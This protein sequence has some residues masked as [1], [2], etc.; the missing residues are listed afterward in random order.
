MYFQKLTITDWKQFDT[1]DIDF[2][3]RLTVFTGA[4]G[5][6]KTTLLHILA[7]HFGWEFSELA[8]PALDEK[9]GGF[10]YWISRLFS[11]ITEQDDKTIT[12][13]EVRYSS[14]TVA[15][16]RLPN[17][18]QAAYHI[19]IQNRQQLYGLNILSHRIPF[20]YQ[21]V[22]SIKTSKISRSQASDQFTDRV[23]Q[24]M[25]TV[26]YYKQQAV[27]YSIK[28]TLLSWAISGAG[29]EFIQPDKQQYDNYIGFERVLGNLLPKNIGFQRLSI[30]N[31]E[32]VFE[33]KSG[34]FMLD[35]VSGGIAALIDIAWQ[36]Y[37][38]TE[39][40]NDIVVLIDEIE[41]HLHATMQREVLPNL[42]KAFP[43]VQFIISTHSP[44]VVSSVKDSN[45]YAFR[46]N[47]SNRVFTEKLDLVGRA[48][49]AI[50]ILDEVLGVSFSMPIWAEESLDAILN[51]YSHSDPTE[52]NVNQMREEL[53][54]N[55][56]E[57]FMPK[58]IINMLDR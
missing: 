14:G 6:G 18:N 5:S 1:V 13:G 22:P 27:N 51:K 57:S 54:S 53:R 30:R 38:V 21:D 32:I 2:H 50:E 49:N 17:V 36:I 25:L 12:I 20:Q 40:D 33:T 52:D 31:Y 47:Q 7:K 9:V 28:E 24:E 39:T 10:K 23:R 16:L 8:T 44:L 15:E 45:I 26:N 29:N 42:L 34:N 43:K 11:K 19:K 35:A 55:G 3:P 37:N 41:N 58:A 56:L 46:Y 4:N 48:R